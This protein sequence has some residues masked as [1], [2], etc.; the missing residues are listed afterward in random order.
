MDKFPDV[1]W[2]DIGTGWQHQFLDEARA[3]LNPLPKV[4]KGDYTQH[5]LAYFSAKR[6]LSIRTQRIIEEAQRMHWSHVELRDNKWGDL[7]AEKQ[8]E[9]FEF[10]EQTLEEGDR[11]RAQGIAGEELSDCWF[12]LDQAT[13]DEY[14]KDARELQDLGW[15][16]EPYR[17]WRMYHQ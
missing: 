4:T 12:D 11:R 6:P 15:D 7:T 13:R 2:N 14:L 17:K 1:S 9:Y 5:Q 10:A 16:P 3:A 8:L